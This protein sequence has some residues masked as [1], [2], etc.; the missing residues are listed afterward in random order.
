MIQL[1]SVII[2]AYNAAPWIRRAVDSVLAQT[3]SPLEVIVIDD[4]STDATVRELE[5]YGAVVRILRKTNGG[6]ASARNAGLAA[7]HGDWIAFLDA[8]D[9][10]LPRKVELQLAAL[11]ARPECHWVYSDAYIARESGPA[12]KSI[13]QR[14]TLHAGDILNALLLEDFISSPTPLVARQVLEELAG[15]DESPQKRGVEDWDMW[16]R[17]ARAHKVLCVGEPLAIYRVHPKS[18]CKTVDL[19]FRMLSRIRVIQDAVRRDPARLERIRPRALARQ[20]M[21]NGLHRLARGQV[22]RAVV[23][24]GRAVRFH[25]GVVKALASWTTVELANA[26]KA[27]AER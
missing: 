1:V 27:A 16:L 3:H 9:E 25:P 20:Y 18:F 13:G 8:D 12:R 19:D 10:W 6:Q 15:F 11:R 23:D 17:L 2:P 5:R 26:L 4:G 22:L 24:M 21:A 14:T 7:A